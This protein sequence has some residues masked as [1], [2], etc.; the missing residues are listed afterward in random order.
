MTARPG[1][2]GRSSDAVSEQF[3][4]ETEQILG[5]DSRS[6]GIDD[7]SDDSRNASSGV[8]SGDTS[9][10]GSGDTSSVGSGDTSGVDHAALREAEHQ[11]H[12]VA[13]AIYGTI[14]ATTVVAAIG[15]GPEELSRSLAVVLVTSAV[16]YAAHVY[17]VAVGAR[18]VARR[19]LTGS[20]VAGIA[21]AEWPMLQ[22]SWPVAVPLLLGK[23]GW[24]PAEA[25]TDV[26]M[27]VGIGALF[28]YGV[29]LGVREGRGWL[30]VVVNALVVGSFGV[31]ILLLKIV[32]H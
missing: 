3:D 7:S 20:E 27:V 24:I 18:M 22:S 19:H 15:P 14:L 8:G 17:S 11:A 16:F 21:A 28:V 6:A 25:A 9:S 23:L 1:Q 32:V 12:K 31:L 26:A 30:S 5:V 29:L 13:G 2:P 10:V 4:H